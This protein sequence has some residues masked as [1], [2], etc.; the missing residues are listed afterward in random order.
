MTAFRLTLP[1]V[2]TSDGIAVEVDGRDVTGE[3]DLRAVQVFAGLGQAT[4]LRLDVLGGGVVEGEGVVEVVRDGS[5]G[6][7][8]GSFLAAVDAEAVERA[9]LERM[10]ASDEQPAE[11]V[12]SVIAVLRG[13]ASG[14]PD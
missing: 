9:A 4:V 7:T 12:R 10:G 11:F 1:A 2:G 3:V 13:L 8:V 6:P 14:A 5:S